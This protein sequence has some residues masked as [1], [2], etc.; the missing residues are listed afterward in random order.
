MASAGHGNPGISGAAAS[1]QPGR[2]SPWL[3]PSLPVDR[4]TISEATS[5]P[6]SNG[7][8]AQASP[9]GPEHPEHREDQEQRDEA[10]AQRHG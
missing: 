4:G 5:L 6:G 3:R 8:C 7:E 1:A 10:P 2:S 9:R